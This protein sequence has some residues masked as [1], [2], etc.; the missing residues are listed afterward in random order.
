MIKMKRFFLVFALIVFVLAFCSCGGNAD[1]SGKAE[2]T[3]QETTEQEKI[4][5]ISFKKE[6]LTDEEDFISEMEGYGAEII[7]K[8]EEKMLLLKFEED[9][10]KTLLKDKYDSTVKAFKEI[11]EDEAQYIEKIEYDEDFR[12]M[13]F[14]VDREGYDAASS[15]V[16]EYVVAANA[17]AYQS[18]LPEGQ[19]SYVEVI[20]S[21]NNETAVTFSMP[22]KF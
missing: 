15:N 1:K 8:S 22:L 5:E 6:T 11:E 14:F 2:T 7:D 16:N 10:H 12:N 19:D 18:F 4:V 3:A 13:K 9:E 20:Y 21:D 17:L